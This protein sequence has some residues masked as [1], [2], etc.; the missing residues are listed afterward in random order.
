MP[1][2][3]KLFLQLLNLNNLINCTGEEFFV[4]MT[5]LIVIMRKNYLS[6]ENQARAEEIAEE[7]F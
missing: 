5:S 2:I 3:Q 1:E 7:F 4:F 6:H